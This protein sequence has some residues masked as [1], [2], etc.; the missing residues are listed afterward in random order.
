ME[1]LRLEVESLRKRRARRPAKT[2]PAVLLI[3]I[4]CVLASLSVLSVWMADFVGNTDRYVATVEPLA[5][6]G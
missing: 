4:A 5:S 2:I 3:I 1:K 6:C